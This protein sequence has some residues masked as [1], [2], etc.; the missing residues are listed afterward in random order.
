MKLTIGCDPE[1]FVRDLL[2]NHVS[3]H[4]MVPGTKDQPFPVKGGAVQVDGTALEF[5]I[6]PATSATGFTRNIEQV[7]RHL[8]SM[9]PENIRLSY[10]CDREYKPDLWAKIPFEAKEL[11]CEPDYNAYSQQE[12][13]I[14]QFKKNSR[15]RTTS[16][17]IH[18][19]WTSGQDPMSYPHWHACVL[20]AKAMDIYLGLP[21]RAMEGTTVRR[22]KLYGRAGAFRPKHYGAEYRVLSNWWLRKREWRKWV[23]KTTNLCVNHLVQHGEGYID[24]MYNTIHNTSCSAAINNEHLV[25]TDPETRNLWY[26]CH[27]LEEA[28]PG[29]KLPEG[30]AARSREALRML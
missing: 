2:G 25:L 17:H 19:G 23:F 10:D 7:M 24:K 29:Y 9:I 30:F 16:G 22:R 18:V 15:L 13:S 14:P 4:G 3:A 1:I 8:K 12:N 20:V 5:N 21:G 11:G 26:A 6:E 28:I 27:V